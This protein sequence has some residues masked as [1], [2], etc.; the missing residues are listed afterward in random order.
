MKRE[1]DD[2]ELGRELVSEARR[3]LSE[4]EGLVANIREAKQEF[5]TAL[6]DAYALGRADALI[7]ASAP[8]PSA[9]DRARALGWRINEEARDE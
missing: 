5:E 1:Q 9:R 2:L 3:L 8:R 4:V 7:G 6:D